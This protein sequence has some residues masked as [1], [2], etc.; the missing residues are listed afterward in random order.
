MEGGGGCLG[1]AV[2][3]RAA[4]GQHDGRNH[5]TTEGEWMMEQEGGGQ[6]NNNRRR[7]L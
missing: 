6:K 3:L 4:R 2:P 5:W 7:R 1:P